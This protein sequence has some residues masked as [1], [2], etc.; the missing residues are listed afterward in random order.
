MPAFPRS[1]TAAVLFT[2]LPL[3]GCYDSSSSNDSFGAD[4]AFRHF[5]DVVAAD[6]DG[7]G[8]TDIAFAF[9]DATGVGAVDVLLNTTSS[10]A[11]IATFAAEQ[12]Y[13]V[14]SFP[15]SL[16]AGDL[17]GDGRLDF[18]T[19]HADS[20]TFTIK[21]QDPVVAGTFPTTRQITQIGRAHV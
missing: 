5:T 7:D 8:R 4:L 6:L 19:T 18:A 16:E 12:R 17:D 21:L 2:L 15:I 11:P 9:R 20:K 10:G 1:T 3:G 13:G 14:A